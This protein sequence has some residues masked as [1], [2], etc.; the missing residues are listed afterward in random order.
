MSDGINLVS[1]IYRPKGKARYPAI[2][3]RTPYGKGSV[4]HS[5]PLIAN[6]FCSQGYAVVIQDIRGKYGSEGVF[7]PFENEYRDGTDT[8]SWVVKQE[9]SDEKV[10]V[11]GFSYLGSCA[12]VMATNSMEPVKTIIP[13]FCCQNAYM[14]WLDYGVPYLKDILMWLLKHHG[15]K[16][17]VVSHEEVDQ[18]ILQLPVLQFDKRLEDGIE[19]F[20]KWMYHLQTDE[21]WMAFSVSHRRHEIDVP[22][23]FIGGWFDRFINNTMVDF[24]ET[25]KVEPTSNTGRSR[26]IVGPWGHRPTVEFPGFNY[27]YYAKFRHQFNPMV[28]WMNHWVKGAK[29]D[30]DDALPIDYFMMG[31]NEW[32]KSACWPPENTEEITYYLGSTKRANTHEGDGTLSLENDSHR[33]SDTYIYNPENP[34][35]SIGNRMLYGNM[36][37]GP[38]EQ[39]K[40]YDREDILFY[41]TAPLEDDIEI[42]GPVKVVLYVSSNAIDT[43]FTAKVCDVFPDGKSFFLINGFV[44][45]RFLDSVKA[46]HGIEANKIYR[47]EFLVSHTAHAFLK[48]HRIQL[49]ISSSDFPNHERNLNTGG[50]NEGDSEEVT[51]KQTLYYGNSHESRLIF[52]VIME[53]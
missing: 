53:S 1:D 13:M 16:G 25:V 28:R 10:V 45:M 49:Q 43:D 33:S 31:K 24:S 42:A 5:Y 46:T 17:R 11:W 47:V 6:I 19:T 21:Y 38:R 9:W 40:L 20:K 22:I 50:S 18:L 15:R 8:V 52:P 34:V 3:I 51:A 12:W 4:S 27:G 14:G 7:Y 32:R 48:G 2:I 37:D 23:L 36:T 41:E 26:L 44:R 29:W 30:F 35:P 39:S